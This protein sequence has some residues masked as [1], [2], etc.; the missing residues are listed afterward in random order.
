MISLNAAL[1]VPAMLVA[2]TLNSAAE[3]RLQIF[4]THVHYSQEAWDIYDAA[5]VFEKLDAAG[6]TRA[7]VSSTPDDGTL[8]LLR[9]D[10]RRV[11]PE[12]RPYHGDFHADN[13]YRSPE[14]IPYL[15]ARLKNGIYRGIGEFHLHATDS[16]RT[17][18]MQ[19]VAALAV[20]NDIPLHIH[21]GAGPVSALFEME[22]TLKIHW[23]HAGMVEP[24]EIVAEM[25]ERHP[26]LTAEVSFR[27]HDIAPG[28]EID[29][30]WRDLFVRHSDRF[31]IGTDTYINDRWDAYGSLIEEHRNWLGQLPRETAQAIAHGNAT[32]VFGEI[33]TPSQ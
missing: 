29:P 33:S 28:G 3:E 18:T 8:T 9:E 11:A 1:I 4:D 5:A 26:A 32:R 2:I 31:M 6:V 22:P 14:I 17:P 23:A 15:E 13:W 10:A 19:R 7:L 30:A 16:A 20:E 25:I 24:A 12:L 27:A 21:S